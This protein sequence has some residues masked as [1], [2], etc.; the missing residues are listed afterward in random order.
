MPS[1]KSWRYLLAFLGTILVL[2][3]SIGLCFDLHLP[4]RFAKGVGL[5][6]AAI[7]EGGVLSTVSA[8]PVELPA[9]LLPLRTHF[10][11]A[12]LIV[13]LAWGLGTLLL[14]LAAGR[15][16]WLDFSPSRPAFNWRDAVALLLLL[17]V[18]GLGC[19]LRA[20]FLLPA[21]DGGIPASNYDEMVYLQA[22]SLWTRGI[23]PYAGYF[24]AHPPGILVALAPAVLGSVPWGGPD[25]LL[26]G[27]W[28][29]LVYG[30]LAVAL[31][32][33]VG[34]QIGGRRAGL[35]AALVLAVDAHA[36]QVAP[37]ETVANLSTLL[38]LWLYVLALKRPPGWTR[39]TLA[40]TSGA[41]AV[42]AA[43]TKAPGAVALALLALL[44][45][46]AWQWRDLL[47]GAVGAALAGL[48]IGLLFVVRDPGAFWRRVVAFQ[49]LRPQETTYGR[50]HLARMADY[51]ESQL[52]FLLLAG[53]I[54]VLSVVVLVDAWQRLRS[55]KGVARLV[56]RP[57]AWALPLAVVIIALLWL[58][59]YGRA[60][61][62]RYY[63]QLIVFFAL[64]VA[65]GFGAIAPRFKV[66]PIWTRIL[67]A[68]VVL[69]GLLF[70]LP[71]IRQQMAV[72]AEVEIDRNYTV[73]GAALTEAVPPE[74]AVLALDPGYPLMAGRPPARFPDGTYIVD[75]AGLMVYHALGIAGMGPRQVWEVARER[76]LEINPQTIFHQPA[77]Q[78]MVVTA[79]YGALSTPDRLGG[80]VASAEEARRP[81]AAAVIDMR[82]AAEDLTP[83]TQEFLR[84][85]GP[86]I[87]WEQYTAAFVVERVGVLGRSRSGLILWDFNMRT[88]SVQGEGPAAQP[89]EPLDVPASGVLQ[90]SLYWFV[91]RPPTSTLQVALELRDG[92]GGMAARVVEP[93]HFGDPPANEWE[94]GWV[95]Q[96][97]HNMPLAPD[98][99]PGEYRLHVSLYAP[100][101][102]RPWE[103]IGEEG[104]ALPIGVVRV[105]Q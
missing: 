16:P 5:W 91:D 73:I 99:V 94:A 42:T 15:R 17:G 97:H 102:L 25:L 74:R 36:V 68:F 26:A 105:G 21:A 95:Y 32:Y 59:S 53:A 89:G 63:V 9:W 50:N 61:H 100:S 2:Y 47:A 67:G 57:A 101:S 88:L 19:S 40:A 49:L 7:D 11:Q 84:T 4:E 8:N 13:W 58:F 27:R 30:L 96:D 82:I 14:F 44:A 72:T 75:G 78:D 60:Y 71:L 35:M 22:T 6:R 28:L 98:M 18:L 85:R 48:V 3:G 66:W 103:W 104:P 86:Q 39:W 10:D 54:I 20:V 23:P 31:L 38:A 90:V 87:A 33:G 92:E 83:Q 69:A 41:A 34:R 12:V 80:E 29:Q 51:P 62:S 77:A 81:P 93:P 79:L 37:L 76:S 45:L 24:L 56:A 1:S 43:L 64:L 46:L 55:R 70:F 52:T 65:A